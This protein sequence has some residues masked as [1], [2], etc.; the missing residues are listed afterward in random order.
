MRNT[1]TPT[2][3]SVGGEVPSCTGLAPEARKEQVFR[4]VSTG[5]TTGAKAKR[6][7]MEQQGVSLPPPRASSQV[8]EGSEE[9]EEEV[10]VD[11]TPAGVGIG[12]TPNLNGRVKLEKVA[13][14]RRCPREAKAVFIT[15]FWRR[16]R[17]TPAQHR[18]PALH[19]PTRLTHPVHVSSGPAFPQQRSIPPP[20]PARTSAAS[21][22]TNSASASTRKSPPTPSRPPTRRRLRLQDTSDLA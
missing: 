21:Q 15:A 5:K 12:F 9:V 11:S 19:P 3:P 8:F 4:N 14:T 13:K 18:R 10:E 16:Q 20:P 2:P 6:R 7:Q 22:T 17:H 1:P